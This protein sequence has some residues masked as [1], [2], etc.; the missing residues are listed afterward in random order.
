[1]VPEMSA[2]SGWSPAR[3]C[4]LPLQGANREPRFA[5]RSHRSVLNRWVDGSEQNGTSQRSHVWPPDPGRNGRCRPT[6]GVARVWKAAGSQVP[7]SR[8]GCSGTA[9]RSLGGRSG[10]WGNDRS[11]VRVRGGASC[12][13]VPGGRRRAVIVHPIEV[14]RLLHGDGQPD[15]VVAAGLLH[16]VLEKTET[17][18]LELELEFGTDIAQLVA[19]VSDDPPIEAYEE[20]E[21]DSREGVELSGCET[22]AIHAADKIAKVRELGLLSAWRVSQR[23]NQAELSHYQASF[24]MLRRAAGHTSLVLCLEAELGRLEPQALARRR[25]AYDGRPSI[26]ETAYGQ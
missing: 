22:L 2:R 11:R 8:A 17:T 26:A 12:R 9:S 20:R 5:G 16:D 23:K 6:L 21:R 19:A 24:E 3:Q 15:H 1:M 13:P 14:G 10:R 25:D 7:F 4:P 18:A